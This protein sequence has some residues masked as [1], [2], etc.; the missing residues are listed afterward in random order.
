MFAI[1]ALSVHLE[2]FQLR[3]SRAQSPA[4]PVKSS[5]LLIFSLFLLTHRLHG[6]EEQHVTNRGA[7]GHQHDH[8]VQAE[9]QATR[10]GHAVLQGVDEVLVHLG[11]DALSLNLR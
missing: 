2:H 5:L 7:V 4:T 8:A 6:G 10:G 11:V 3:V 1:G 9:A